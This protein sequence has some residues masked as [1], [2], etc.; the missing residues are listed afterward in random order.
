MSDTP[1]GGPFDKAPAEPT[2]AE[3]LRRLDAAR[4]LEYARSRN[5]LDGAVTG[6]SP[7]LTHGV[8]GM[9]EAVERIAQR[10]PIGLAD[11]LAFEFGWREFFHHVW[12][13][14]GDAVL[15]DM[16]PARLWPGRPAD[17]LPA[18]IREGRTGVPAIDT[19][20]RQLYATGH[21]HNHARMWLA[22][23]V[24][25]LRKVS[26]RAGA[27]WLYGHL[28][29]GDVPSNH[30]SW[31]W[32]AATFS[33]K[34]Y[35]FNAEN[36]ARFAPRAGGD[37]WLSPATVIDTSYEA[38]DRIAREHGDV[39]AEPGVHEGVVE[40]LLLAHPPG[41]VV[42]AV[43]GHFGDG[44]R[45]TRLVHPWQLGEPDGERVRLGVVHLPAHA[46]L[47]WSERRWRWVLARMAA[48]T[49]A[50]FIGD[51]AA[52]EVSGVA[53]A[54]RAPIPGYDAALARHAAL[55]PA[56]RWLPDPERLCT[57]FSRFYQAVQR[58]QAAAQA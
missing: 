37:K 35:L 58:D 5:A 45:E 8:I 4:P 34:P 25:H 12:S 29:D 36:V 43:F 57:S 33:R 52:L 46:T 28:L 16:H 32:V 48:V 39:G 7:Y 11:K 53:T 30:L 23:Y 44:L 1:G 51:L 41:D 27:D 13:H 2:R 31:Q 40:P 18:D 21:L 38:L 22:S 20:V 14:C 47:A 10:H 24:V 54:T 6:L 55:L 56:P 50:V 17:V 3:A 9:R 42:G 49:E 15:H 26:W 19:A